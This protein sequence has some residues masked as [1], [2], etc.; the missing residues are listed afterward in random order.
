MP[1]IVEEC[2]ALLGNSKSII[3][4]HGQNM[5]KVLLIDSDEVKII[6]QINGKKRGEL[7][8]P[9]NTSEKMFLMRL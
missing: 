4:V 1:H 5:K 2:W 9:I 3:E 6:V 7:N 8:L